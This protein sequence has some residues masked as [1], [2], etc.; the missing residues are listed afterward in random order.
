VVAEES[1]GVQVLEALFTAPEAPEIAA[2]VTTTE[3]EG[4]RRPLVAAAAG[5]MGLDVRST[6]ELRNESFANSLRDFGIDLL[7]NVHSLFVLDADVVRAPRIG[8]FNLHPGPLPEYAGLNA[9]S[10]AIY[11]GRSVHEAT[12]HW[13]DPGIDTGAI[14]YRASFEIEET[15]TGLSLTA[16]CVRHGVPLVLKLI[17]DATSDPSS[18]PA[19]EQ[20]LRKRRYFGREVPNDG[21]LDWNAPAHEVVRFIR[22]ADYG[23]FS[24]PWGT[25]QARLGGRPVGIVKASLSGE[26][27]DVPPGSVG[28]AGE[29]GAVIVATSDEWIAVRRIQVEGRSMSPSEVCSPGDR[30]DVRKRSQAP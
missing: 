5:R 3:S 25:P 19:L 2:V 21:N 12:L 22:A 29:R 17:A 15:D 20:D 14:A 24:S 8:S 23:P 26:A 9:P 28:E 1:A 11:E 16:K 7:L 27:T 18:I 6:A 10:W 13:M 4:M 30:F